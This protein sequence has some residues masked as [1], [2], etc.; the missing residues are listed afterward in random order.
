MFNKRISD[1]IGCNRGMPIG[2]L[3]NGKSGQAARVDARKGCCVHVYIEGKPVIR[4]LFAYA[5]PNRTNLSFIHIHAARITATV[6]K[7]VQ[8]RP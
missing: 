7:R 8:V 5:Q 2:K 6:T 1:S 4:T 3:S